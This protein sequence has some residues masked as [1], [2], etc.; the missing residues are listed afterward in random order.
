MTEGA[1]DMAA[2]ATDTAAEA[3][4][5]AADAAADAAETTTDAAADATE[6]AEQ[7][8]D[9]VAAPE[10]S[11]E[12]AK[13]VLTVDGFDLEKA[14]GLIEAAPML[15]D[16]AKATVIS[17]IEQAQNNPVILGTILEKARTLL[18]L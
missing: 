10:F 14:K 1:A 11:M 7:A 15:D 13:E 9:E 8:V 6:A 17:G 16:A 5:S 12:A 2:D 3:T 18:G 4:E